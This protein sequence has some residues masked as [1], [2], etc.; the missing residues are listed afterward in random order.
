M[1]GAVAT[2]PFDLCCFSGKNG[3]QTPTFYH[4]AI[5]VD[6]I[7]VVATFEASISCV[8]TPRAE[9]EM[10]AHPRI[11]TFR[12]TGDAGG[13]QENAIRGRKKEH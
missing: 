11:Y 6:R 9:L 1:P 13:K 2:L 4:P 10:A 12:A 8:S 7:D 3:E 5:P